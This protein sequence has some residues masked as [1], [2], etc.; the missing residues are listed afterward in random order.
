MDTNAIAEKYAHKMRIACIG[1]T[2]STDTLSVE[3]GNWFAP[4]L[5]ETIK[6]AIAEATHGMWTDED[7]VK[8]FQF[9]AKTAIREAKK[10]V[11]GDSIANFNPER[12]FYQWLAEYKQRRKKQ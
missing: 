10:A 7:M 4:K 1:A 11:E 8:A 12:E 2:P 6:Q 9:G 5:E 3:F